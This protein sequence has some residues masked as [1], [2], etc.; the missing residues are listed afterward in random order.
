[1][2]IITGKRV[3]PQVLYNLDTAIP[4]EEMNLS[5][6]KSYPWISCP[7]VFFCS[8]RYRIISSAIWTKSN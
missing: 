1:L 3:W 6:V 5:V 7:G 2:N 4:Y 8:H